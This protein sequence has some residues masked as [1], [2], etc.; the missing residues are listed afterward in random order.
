MRSWVFVGYGTV[1]PEYGWDDYKGVDVKGKVLVM[2]VND[3]PLEDENMFGGKAMTY[4]GRWT[5]KF[6]IAAEKQAAG[7]LV[8]HE[9]EPAGYPWEVVSG[10]WSGEQFDLM[11]PDRNAGAGRSGRLAQPQGRAGIGSHGREKV[12]QIERGGRKP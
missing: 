4:Y 12:P 1:A 3:P 7:C 2:L 10:G 6:E 9:T 8:I 5:Y 11:T